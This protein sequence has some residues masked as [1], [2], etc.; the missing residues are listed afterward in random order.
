MPQVKEPARRVPEPAPERQEVFI[1]YTRVDREWVDRLQQMMKPLLRAGGQ[2]VLLWD[3]SQILAGAK[4]RAEIEAALA[5]AKVALLLVSAAFLDSEFVMNALSP[6]SAAG[7][8][9]A[10]RE[11]G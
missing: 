4:W 5:R 2:R 9:S 8:S 10:A 11:S 3:D 1:S 7:W 6:P